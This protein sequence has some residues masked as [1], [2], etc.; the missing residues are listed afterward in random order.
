MRQVVEVMAEGH[1]LMAICI[2]QHSW[3]NSRPSS[4]LG[5]A[6]FYEAVHLDFNLATTLSHCHPTL[7]AT[8]RSFELKWTVSH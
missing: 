3:T 4:L 7:S 6:A 1:L 8:S 2:K 5:N